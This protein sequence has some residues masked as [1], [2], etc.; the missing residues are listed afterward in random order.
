MVTVGYH[1][2][3][4]PVLNFVRNGSVFSIDELEVCYSAATTYI[5]IICH[6]FEIAREVAPP[7]PYLT[8]FSTLP[9]LHSVGDIMYSTHRTYVKGLR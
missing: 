3:L 7:M 6:C 5:Y 8:S 9:R 4:S 1:S 2:S